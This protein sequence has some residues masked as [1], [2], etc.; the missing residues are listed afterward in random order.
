MLLSSDQLLGFG[1]AALILIVI[2]GPSVVFAIS[3]AVVY[4]QRVALASVVGNTV[5]L[6]LVMVLVALG[7]GLV[8]AQSVVV[9]TVLKFA[10]AAY[11]VW[12]GIQAFRHRRRMQVGDAA[13]PVA[14]SWR[15]A[16]RQGFV[17]GVSNPKAFMI[18]AAVLPPFVA[19]DR[20]AIP[21]QMFLLGLVAVAI[22]LVCDS[23]W[24]LAA[25]R[26]R[27]WFAGSPR[28]GHALGAIGGSSMVA[29]GVGMALTGRHE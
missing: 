20:G 10:G 17:V 21:L 7:L 13:P 16:V 27:A 18:F 5:G 23:L 11:L 25:G 6:F 2:P 15:R 1:L 14:M 19:T 26:A 28:R 29:L 3:R 24:A 8:V 12:L 4:G 9:F 22:G